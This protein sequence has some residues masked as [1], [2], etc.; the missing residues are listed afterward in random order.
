MYASEM[1][2]R[3]YISDSIYYK[4]ENK[5]LNVRYSKLLSPDPVDTRSGDDIALD[6]IKRL[7]LRVDNEF[8]GISSENLA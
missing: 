8:N 2:F 5:Y 7:G 3:N 1:L 4:Q 6:V